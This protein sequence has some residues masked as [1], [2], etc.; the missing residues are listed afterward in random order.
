MPFSTI[1][2]ITP[3]PFGLDISDSSLKVVKLLKKRGG[4][5]LENFGDVDIGPGI[6]ADGIILDEDKLAL[7]IK[8]GL[9]K[10]KKGAINSRYVSCSLPEQKTYLRMIQLDKT[11]KENIKEAVSW[12]IEANIP[13]TVEESYFDWQIVSPLEINEKTAPDHFDLLVSV[14]PKDLVDSYSS[15]LSKAGLIPFSFEPESLAISRSL[16]KGEFSPEPL[17]IVDMGQVRTSFLIY[18]GRAL[19]FTSSIK[20]SGDAITEVITRDLKVSK[21][22]AERLKRDVGLDRDV[23]PNVFEA[24]IS[25]MTDL[26][27]Q[28]EKYMDFYKDHV[29]HT[30]DGDGGISK[31][32]LSG[33]GA[34]MRGLEKYLAITLNVPVEIG[35]PWVNILGGKIKS[36]PELPY[37]ESVRYATALGLALT[38]PL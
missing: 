14:A 37:E 13:I 27:E 9:G 28:L 33:G 22:E 6:V 8:N 30:H 15:T 17:L 26:K 11:N 3:E 36:L 34:S 21:N 2:K 38:R 16:I 29:S 5:I 1:F 12:E 31:V 23:D 7:L 18:A 19:R 10:L 35:N 20:I 25:I 24:V 4:F 32:L